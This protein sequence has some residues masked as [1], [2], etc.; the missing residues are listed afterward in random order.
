MDEIIDYE[1][2]KYNDEFLV[3]LDDFKAAKS[4][5]Y[6]LPVADDM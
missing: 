1:G 2:E 5:V 4:D 3:Q 6:N